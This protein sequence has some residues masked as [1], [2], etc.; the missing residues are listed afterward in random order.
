MSWYM[1][2]D[3]LAAAMV[4]TSLPPQKSSQYQEMILNTN[5]VYILQTIQNT[6]GW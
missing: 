2:T 6:K 3:D 5:L 1:V 4:L